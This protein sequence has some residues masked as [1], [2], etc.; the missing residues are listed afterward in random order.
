[1]PPVI[2]GTWQHP[3]AFTVTATMNQSMQSFLAM[4]KKC[5]RASF[6]SIVVVA[7]FE[8]SQCSHASCKDYTLKGVL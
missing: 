2:V 5:C 4:F 1:M 6:S 8:F 7:Q 3:M